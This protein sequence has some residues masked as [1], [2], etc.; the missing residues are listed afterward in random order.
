MIEQAPVL[1]VVIP[2]ISAFLTPLIGWGKKELCYPWVILSLALS[3]FCT[4][5][6][7]LT[8]IKTGT[9]H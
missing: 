8:V 6:T 3:G 7:F 9:I 5:I 2:L 4:I 1:I